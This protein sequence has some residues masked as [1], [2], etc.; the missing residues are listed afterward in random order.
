L[1]SIDYIEGALSGKKLLSI[2]SWILPY[3]NLQFF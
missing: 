3:N 1:L 2:W